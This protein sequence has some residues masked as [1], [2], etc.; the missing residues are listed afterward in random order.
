MPADL[1]F[2]ILKPLP[3]SDSLLSIFLHPSQ[4][5][6][7]TILSE[8][9]SHQNL[10]VIATRGSQSDWFRYGADGQRTRSWGSDGA[11][12]YLPGYEHRT[13]TGQTK[14][15]VG[16]YAVI[17]HTAQTGGNPQRKVE[18]LL[19]DRLGSV[20]AVADSSGILTE[21]RGY[22]AFG[23]PRTGAW[24]DLAPP[25]LGS[26]AVTPK[27]FTQH[28]HLNQLELIHMNGRVYDYA[29]GRF[30]GVDPFIQFPLNSQSLNPYAYILNNPLSGTDPTG[31]L[32]GCGFGGMNCDAS[33]PLGDNEGTDQCSF[34]FHCQF[35]F[36]ENGSKDGAGSENGG[37]KGASTSPEARKH[38]EGGLKTNAEKLWGMVKTTLVPNGDDLAKRGAEGDLL[39]NVIGYQASGMN[40]V[41]DAVNTGINA[42]PVWGIYNH[43]NSDAPIEI[44]RLHINDNELPGAFA[45]DIVTGVAT[46]G[47]TLIRG[48]AGVSAKAANSAPRELYRL[49]QPAK[50]LERT[51]DHALSPQLYVK[52]VATHYGINLRGSG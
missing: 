24:A 10:P 38:S 46:A 41:I 2:H 18:Y 45:N 40:K 29:L 34:N 36:G 23:K 30:T 19:K 32:I 7:K 5:W 48:A 37:G 12:I 42:T 6:P 11:R 51:F 49:G 15:Y 39:T 31:Y 20:D 16:D 21:T 35:A 26:T 22:D 33:G 3:P 8:M 28:E 50:P 9:N 4:K 44:S 43:F 17:T 1:F 13:D 47:V 52:D 27:G 25:K 14:T